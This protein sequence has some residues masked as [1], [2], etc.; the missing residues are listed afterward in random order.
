MFFREQKLVRLAEM[1][2][3]N[4][5]QAAWLPAFFDKGASMCKIDHDLFYRHCESSKELRDYLKAG[6]DQCSQNTALS[7]YKTPEEA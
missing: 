5:V 7:I 6:I 1:M 2:S 4:P 3:L